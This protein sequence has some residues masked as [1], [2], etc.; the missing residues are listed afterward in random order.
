MFKKLTRLLGNIVGR[1]KENM[2]M[3]LM[4]IGSFLMPLGFFLLFRDN[5]E[6]IFWETMGIVTILFGT[7]VW[8]IAG[9]IVQERERQNAREKVYLAQQLKN[10]SEDIVS[11]IKDS[12]S[13]IKEL[14]NEIRKDR[15]ERN[16][17]PK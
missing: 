7:V 3:F 2:E 14:A 12:V 5:T 6:D 9:K 13:S 16:N 15:N 17:K 11:S 1:I 10:I 8:L 4:T